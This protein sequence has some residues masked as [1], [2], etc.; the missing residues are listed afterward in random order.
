MYGIIGCAISTSC[1]LFIG[2]GLILNWYYAKRIHLDIILFWK[3]IL[4][5]S[6]PFLLSASLMIFLNAFL[7]TSNIMCF[8]G[9]IALYTILC[10]VFLWYSGFNTFEKSQ[11]LNPMS[12]IKVRLGI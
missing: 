9:K 8:V 5:L 1:A 6:F 12:K 4:H 11:I 2:H 7:T 10:F 3:Q